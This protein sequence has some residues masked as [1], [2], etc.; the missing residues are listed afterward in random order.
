[1]LCIRAPARMR[2]IILGLTFMVQSKWPVKVFKASSMDNFSYH[3]LFLYR[4]QMQV[5]LWTYFVSI[6]FTPPHCLDF[7]D[8]L[9]ILLFMWLKWIWMYYVHNNLQLLWLYSMHPAFAIEVCKQQAFLTLCKKLIN[10][11]GKGVKRSTC[12]LKT[13]INYKHNIWYLFDEK[14]FLNYFLSCL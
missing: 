3:S 2:G 8:N 13:Y 12:W 10:N 14:I 11:I 7:T 9:E 4:R 1:M 5:S 6:Y